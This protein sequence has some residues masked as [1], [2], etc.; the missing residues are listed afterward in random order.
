MSPRELDPLEFGL[1][2]YP[3][4]GDDVLFGGLQKDC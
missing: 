3:S 4:Q 1:Q 2:M